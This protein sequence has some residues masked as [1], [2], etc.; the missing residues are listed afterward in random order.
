MQN[1]VKS[2]GSMPNRLQIQE[3]VQLCRAAWIPPA[4]AGHEGFRVPLPV[5]SWPCR[6]AACLWSWSRTR[7]LRSSII[8]KKHPGIE[9]PK[10]N[11]NPENP[12]RKRDSRLIWKEACRCFRSRLLAA[13]RSML[14]AILSAAIGRRSRYLFYDTW[15]EKQRNCLDESGLFVYFHQE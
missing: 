7:K 10:R 5:P 4:F 6:Y 13:S 9:I 14:C 2:E 3:C 8:G 15:P 1:S 12:F 11:R